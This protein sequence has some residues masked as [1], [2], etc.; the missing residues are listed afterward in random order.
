[1]NLRHME[2]VIKIVENKS[3]TKAANAL[4]IPQPSL[5]QSILSLEKELGTPIFNRSTNP[6]SLTNAGEIYYSKVNLIFK[7]ID[8]L[9]LDLAKLNDAQTSKIRIGFSQNG[10]RM[11]PEILPKFCKRF[12]M[13]SIKILQASSTLKLRQMLLDGEIDVGLLMLP[14]D[15]SGLN[16]EIIKTQKTFLALPVLHPLSQEF[17][18][19]KYPKISI[20]ELGNEKF[21]L[22]RQNQRS[23]K[24]FEDIFKKHGINPE[25]LCEVETFEVANHMVASGVGACFTIPELLSDKN[26]VKL[27]DI[28]EPN[29]EKTLILA[30]RDDY[31]PSPLARAFIDMAK[32]E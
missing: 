20:K 6:I 4:K 7:I 28:G 8:D 15:V 11:I 21:I 25:I 19:Q 14:M 3:F 29:L 26:S 9:K 24:I 17:S 23:R 10:Y 31:E 16:Y 5:S 22:P 13:A 18:A 12:D 32:S 1:M 2:L 30:Y 27:F